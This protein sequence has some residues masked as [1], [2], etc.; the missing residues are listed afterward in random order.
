MA[1]NLTLTF[2]NLHVYTY[3]SKPNTS[4]SHEYIECVVTDIYRDDYHE[5]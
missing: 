3:L 4:L 5:K 2:F 1:F